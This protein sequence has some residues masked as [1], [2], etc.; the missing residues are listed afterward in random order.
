VTR[1]ADGIACGGF[2]PRVLA[3]LILSA[4]LGLTACGGDGSSNR[5]PS[6]AFTATPS[7]GQAPLTVSF[8]ASASSDRDGSI[9]SYS[10]NF[11]DGTAPGSGVSVTHSYQAAGTFTTTLTVTDNRGKSAST[12][13]VISVTVGP[14]AGSVTV[15]GRV[16]FERVP[17]LPFPQD[18]L[19]YP[20]TFAA[21]AREIEVELLQADNQAVLA[22]AST[23]VDG[24]YSLAAPANTDVRVRAKA[25]S[26]VTGT[27]ARPAAWDLRV[28]NNTNGNALY[29]LDS[30]VFNTGAADV[31]RNL[32]ATT[33]W[34]GAFA[35]NYTGVRASA[36]FAVLDTLYS[37]TQFVIAQGDSALQL[38]PLRAFWSEQNRPSEGDPAAGNIGTTLYGTA[39]SFGNEIGI[40]VLGAENNDTDEFDQHVLAHEYQH[41][42][43]DAISRTDSV[44]GPHSLGERLD[45]RLAFSEGFANAYSAMVLDDPRYRD[46]FGTAQGADFNFNIETDVFSV[47]GWYS[48]ASIHRIV[49]DLYDTTNDAADSDGVTIGYGPMFD[50]FRAELRNDTPLTSLFAFISALKQQPSMPVAAIDVRVEAEGVPGTNFGIDSQNIDAYATTETHSSVAPVS[51]DLVLPIYSEIALNGPPVRLCGDAEVT[52]PG[53]DVVP[54]TYNKL[55]NRRF[56]KFSVPS[57]RIIDVQVTCRVTDPTCVGSPQPDPDLVLSQ[58]PSLQFSDSTDA[59]TERLQTPVQAGEHVLEIYEYSHIDTETTSRRGRTCMTVTITG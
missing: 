27:T 10:W 34:G 32:T 37:A 56:L 46:S 42:L 20:G 23:D 2:L 25:L 41:F 35:G 19:D 54:G 14:P 53:G 43:E 45:M 31:T 21:P 51:A 8:D 59:F 22:N 24:N 7:S 3:I 4:A 17:F 18:G 28:L 38:P 57:A 15:S 11:G 47:P 1:H 40:Y 58:G 33:G 39:G 36:P 26:R 12:T 48:E 30:S 44:G 55:G 6:A 9:S 50:V 5:A 49:W 29:V 52:A 16:A 13:R